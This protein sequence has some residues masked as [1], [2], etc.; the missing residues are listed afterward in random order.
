MPK[1]TT[2]VE[3]CRQFVIRTTKASAPDDLVE[4]GE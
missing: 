3:T 4:R 1:E 2:S